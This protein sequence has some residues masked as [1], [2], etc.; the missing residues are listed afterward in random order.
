MNLC[1][2]N[3]AIDGKVLPTLT[4]RVN[5]PLGIGNFTFWKRKCL[6]AVS[7]CVS[8]ISPHRGRIAPR[9]AFMNAALQSQEVVAIVKQENANDIG[10]KNGRRQEHHCMSVANF[11]PHQYSLHTLDAVEQISPRTIVDPPL[12]SERLSKSELAFL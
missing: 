2:A 1:Q 8:E 7:G 4:V 12:F 10:E 5:D 9:P 6:K 11:R 3:V